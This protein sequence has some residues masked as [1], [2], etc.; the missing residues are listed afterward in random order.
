MIALLLLFVFITGSAPKAFFHDLIADHNDIAACT[1][2]HETDVLHPHETNC[3]FNDLVVPAPYIF[4]T[5]I[6][7]FQDSPDFNQYLSF[8]GIAYFFTYTKHKENRGPPIA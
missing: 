6:Y 8:I 4:E 7:K 2:D 3:D 1:I 5:G